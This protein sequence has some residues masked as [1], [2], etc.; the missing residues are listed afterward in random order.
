MLGA[1]LLAGWSISEILPYPVWLAF[2]I[3][4]SIGQIVMFSITVM[5][6]TDFERRHLFLYIFTL[7]FYWPLGALATYKAILELFI[8]PFYWDKTEHGMACD[9]S[10]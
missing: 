7:P 10:P 4:M 2:I 5:A 6:T 1:H 9:K 3:T 8:A